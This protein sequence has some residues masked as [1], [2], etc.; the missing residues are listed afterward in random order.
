MNATE[1]AAWLAERKT[2]IGGS[3]VAAIIGVSP[4][5]TA[6]DVFLDKTGQTPDWE[7]NEATYWGNV[8]EDV[9]AQE[10]TKRSGAKVQR[11]NKMLRH[12]QH[13]FALANVD[14]FVVSDGTRVRLNSAG[15]V[16]GASGLLECKTASAYKADAWKDGDDDAVPTEYVAQVMWYLGVTGLKWADVACL[17]GGQR[18]VCKRIKHDAAVI[19]ALFDRCGAFWRDHILTGKAPEPTTGDDAAKLFGQDDG[20][21]VEADPKTLELIYRARDLK[22]QIASLELELDGDKKRGVMG[23]TGEIKRRIGAHAGI[24]I[25]GQTLCT[26]K[27]AKPSQKIDWQAAFAD[28]T[29]DTPQ[30]IAALIRDTH[31]TTTPGSRRLLIKE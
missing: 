7:G 8:L 14:R 2:G 15:Q 21:L 31:T 4:Y 20:Q 28:A 18:Y 10:Y 27:A 12:P 5:K 23:I 3:D 1:R 25:G 16:E 6:V 11:L 17:V 24:Q 26:W 9:V 30:E 19:D 13:E 22:S 29:K